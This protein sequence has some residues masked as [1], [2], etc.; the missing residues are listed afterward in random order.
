MHSEVRIEGLDTESPTIAFQNNRCCE[1]REI[2][3]DGNIV[4]AATASADRMFFTNLRGSQTVDPEGG[5]I[6]G[7]PGS[8]QIDVVGS[9]GMPLIAGAPDIDYSGTLIVD[10]AEGNV[11]FRGAVSQFPAFEVYF[12]VN[13]GTTVSLA[14]L[15]PLVSLALFGAQSRSVDVSTR[16]LVYLLFSIGNGHQ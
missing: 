4:A 7:I 10:R 6:E 1:S 5:V 14:Q 13:D 3:S 16:I 9:A 2:D 8:I 11:L 15:P 12:F